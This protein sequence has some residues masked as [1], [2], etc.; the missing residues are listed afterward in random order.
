MKSQVC[1]SSTVRNGPWST[2]PGRERGNEGP[3]SG[4]LW[5]ASSERERHRALEHDLAADARD[6]FEDAHAAPDP[7]D[8]R[9]DLEHVPGIDR[10]PEAD[11]LDAGEKGEPL[12][13]LGLRQD[14]DGANLRD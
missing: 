5:L 6:A 3:P 1:P 14:Q 4:V 12:L 10:M 13:V 8:V 11:A 7:D 2:L 9:F